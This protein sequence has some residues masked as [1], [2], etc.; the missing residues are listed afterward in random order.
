MNPSMFHFE[1]CIK[2]PLFTPIMLII[3]MLNSMECVSLAAMENSEAFVV[4]LP[5]W[6]HSVSHILFESLLAVVLAAVAVVVQL[7]VLGQNHQQMVT[8]SSSTSFFLFVCCC[9]SHCGWFTVVLKIAPLWQK[10]TLV[11][12]CAKMQPARFE[13]FSKTQHLLLE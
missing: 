11:T 2:N 5:I 7:L 8:F 9:F 4:W 3:N 10:H 12:T 6:S 1:N 13:P